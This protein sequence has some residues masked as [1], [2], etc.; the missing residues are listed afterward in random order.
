MQYNPQYW[1]QCTVFMSLVT[2]FLPFELYHYLGYNEFCKLE[3]RNFGLVGA[4][5]PAH[6]QIQFMVPL[7]TYWKFLQIYWKFL[8]SALQLCR[9][10]ADLPVYWEAML[11]P[12]WFPWLRS[13][14][15]CFLHGLLWLDTFLCCLTRPVLNS[16][17]LK[18]LIPL[19]PSS[20]S[21]TLHK[22]IWTP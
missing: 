16:T 20:L 2:H 6:K 22:S 11:F 13:Q 8:P 5:M 10:L 21:F 17:S 12:V 18:A 7:Q 3:Y 19:T 15:L 4:C 14:V 9:N 1:R